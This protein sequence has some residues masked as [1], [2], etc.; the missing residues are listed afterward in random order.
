[1]IRP[2]MISKILIISATSNQ[3]NDL[4]H[5]FQ[6]TPYKSSAISPLEQDQMFND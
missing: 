5:M 1:M 2:Y 3:L 4:L 6:I